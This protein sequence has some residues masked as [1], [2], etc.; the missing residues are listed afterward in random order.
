MIKKEKVVVVTG[1]SSGIGLETAKAMKQKGCKVYEFSR[2]GVSS[3]GITHITADVT[4]ENAVRAG[5]ENIISKE[6][7]I[8]VVINCAGYGLAGAIEFTETADAKKQFDVNF[9][10]MVNVNRAVI[11]HM[12]ERGEG[13]IVNISSVAADAAIPFQ[14][15]YSASKAA[16]DSYTCALRNEVKPFGITAVAIQPGDICTP[17]TKARNKV[18]MG[19]DVY[20]GQ[21]ARSIEKMEEDERG[22]MSP[23]FAGNYIS[24]IA[25]KRKVKPKYAIGFTYKV[26]SFLLKVLPCN[27]SNR[28]IGKM[29]CK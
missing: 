12:R 21:I 19:D 5:I 17:F 11:A 4:D 15:Y 23:S 8:D 27:F 7:A 16:I 10:G 1:G 18:L 6:N 2:Q 22:G 26:L 28:I 29:Y 24:K 9:F 3:E 13:R 25:L 20:G 14:A